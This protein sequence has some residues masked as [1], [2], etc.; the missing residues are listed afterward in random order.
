[1]LLG[2]SYVRSIALVLWCALCSTTAAQTVEDQIRAEVTRYVDAINRGDPQA[3][4]ALYLDDPSTSSVGDG[5]I[6]QGWQTIAGVYHEVYAQAGTI[7]MSVDSV[8]VFPLAPTV[9]LAV[10]RYRWVIGRGSSPDIGAMT[11]LYRRTPQGWRIAHDHASTFA[12]ARPPTAPS[13]PPTDSGPSQP[14]RQ[15]FPCTVTRIIDGDTIECSGAGRIRLI[16]IDTPE[17]NQRPFGIRASSALAALIALGAE[18]QLEQDVEA[19]DRYG[20]LLAYVWSDGTLVNWR[21]IREGWAVL[22][23]YPP[24]VQYVDWFTDAQR[25]AREEGRGLW[26]VAGFDC[27]PV[28]RRRGRCE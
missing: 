8:S 1:M 2:R 17:L 25:R 15:T 12:E 4:A 10:M 14:V 24:N 5:R 27:L 19:R 18:V 20:R 3:I 13:A 22:L 26:A 23:T 7:A 11:L 6:Y 9:A 21:M 16:G 28:D